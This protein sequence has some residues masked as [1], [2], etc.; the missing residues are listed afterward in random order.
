MQALTDGFGCEERF[1][2]SGPNSLQPRGFSA[3]AALRSA[4]PSVL[5]TPAYYHCRI[6]DFRIDSTGDE[7]VVFS[8]VVP[9]SVC[10]VVCSVDWT[11]APGAAAGGDT[12]T[13]GFP[14]GVGNIASCTTSGTSSSVTFDTFAGKGSVATQSLRTLAN[15]GRNTTGCVQ[16]RLAGLAVPL[17][18]CAPAGATVTLNHVDL[19]FFTPG[20]GGVEEWIELLLVIR[21][22][23]LRPNVEQVEDELTAVERA[24]LVRFGALIRLLADRVPMHLLS[25]IVQYNCPIFAVERFARESFPGADVSRAPLQLE[26][27]RRKQEAPS[28]QPDVADWVSIGEGSDVARI[29]FNDNTGWGDIPLTPSGN[30]VSFAAKVT[31]TADVDV[32]ER[33]ARGWFGDRVDLR[34]A[35]RVPQ[36]ASGF[37]ARVRWEVE[38]DGAFRRPDLPE[39]DDWGER[40][41]NNGVGFG[42]VAGDP[43]I[44]GDGD[45]RDYPRNAWCGCNFAP[46]DVDALR[47]FG[48]HTAAGDLKISAMLSSETDTDYELIVHACDIFFFSG[49]DGFRPMDWLRDAF[50]RCEMQQPPHE[51]VFKLNVPPRS[52]PA[53]AKQVEHDLAEHAQRSYG[54]DAMAPPAAHHT[55]LVDVELSSSATP[56]ALAPVHVP[57]NACGFVAK[58]TWVDQGYGAREGQIGFSQFNATNFFQEKAPHAKGTF[59]AACDM[60]P[61]EGRQ[62]KHLLGIVDDNVPLQ[63]IVGDVSGAT[64]IIDRLDVVVFDAP[65]AGATRF[66]PTEWLAKLRNRALKGR[67]HFLRLQLPPPTFS[68]P[69]ADGGAALFDR[70]MLLM[71][72]PDAPDDQ[73]GL[74][75]TATGSCASTH[76][77]AARATVLDVAWTFDALHFVTTTSDE[78]VHLFQA[79]NSTEPVATYHSSSGVLNPIAVSAN[80]D[81]PVVVGGCGGDVLFW[82]YSSGR[83]VKGRAES[84]VSLLS[85]G[86][87]PTTT[88]FVASASV[89]VSITLWDV[90]SGA[91][92]WHVATSP[93]RGVTFHSMCVLWAEPEVLVGGSDGTLFQYSGSGE[94]VD[95]SDT[96]KGINVLC[97]TQR[98]EWRFYARHTVIYVEDAYGADTQT[99]HLRGGHGKPIVALDASRDMSRL[100][101]SC[102]D[103]KVVVWDL[104]ALGEEA[105]VENQLL[106]IDVAAVAT[107]VLLSPAWCPFAASEVDL[108]T[109]PCCHTSI[110]WSAGA[111]LQP[112]ATAIELGTV[113]VPVGAT[114]FAARIQW[115]TSVAEAAA[116]SDSGSDNEEDAG[117]GGAARTACRLK[118][119]QAVWPSTATVGFSGIGMLNMFDGY[120]PVD[121][122]VDWAAHDM[123]AAA[124]AALSADTQ[125][126]GYAKLPLVVSLPAAESAV[127]HKLDVV[128]FYPDTDAAQELQASHNRFSPQEWLVRALEHH[129][130]P[131][132][133]GWRSRDACT[134]RTMTLRDKYCAKDAADLLGLVVGVP[135]DRDAGTHVPPFAHER[136][137][138]R[139]CRWATS[140]GARLERYIVH[141]N[142]R[143]IK[144]GA[145]HP[146]WLKQC[147]ARYP[148]ASDVDY[149]I[150]TLIP[151]CGDEPPY[152]ETVPHRTELAGFE[153]VEATTLGGLLANVVWS[154]NGRQASAAVA[155]ELFASEQRHESDRKPIVSVPNIF[156]QHAGSFGAQENWSVSPNLTFGGVAVLEALDAWLMDRGTFLARELDG[157]K[158]DVKV[159]GVVANHCDL[160]IERLD[161]ALFRNVG[162]ANADVFSPAE[163]ASAAHEHYGTAA[164][165]SFSQ[166][167]AEWSG[168]RV[169][170]VSAVSAAFMSAPEARDDDSDDPESQHATDED[171][172]G[173]AFGHSSDG[174]DVEQPQTRQG[175]DDDHGAQ[176][177]GDADEVWDQRTRRAVERYVS[178]IADVGSFIRDGVLEQFYVASPDAMETVEEDVCDVRSHGA[179]RGLDAYRHYASGLEH[180]TDVFV[181][182][183]QEEEA[184]RA[185]LT[186]YEDSVFIDAAVKVVRQPKPRAFGPGICDTAPSFQDGH[187]CKAHLLY[188]LPGESLERDDVLSATPQIRCTIHQKRLIPAVGDV[189]GDAKVRKRYTCAQQR[190]ATVFNNI[191]RQYNDADEE[192]D[193]IDFYVCQE[194]DC[195][196]SICKECMMLGTLDSIAARTLQTAY[197]ARRKGVAA[198]IGLIMI[199]AA[200]SMYLPSVKNAFTTVFCHV[201]LACVYPTC[202]SPPEGVFL[203]LVLVGGLVLLFIGVGFIVVLTL[204]TYRR[205]AIILKSNIVDESA[206]EFV[207]KTD[208]HRVPT[209]MLQ[210]VQCDIPRHE[211]SFITARDQSVFKGVYEQYEFRYMTIHASLL[212]FKLAQLGVVL[213]L[214]EPNSLSQLMGAAGVEFAQLVFFSATNPFTNPWIDTLS[215]A[216]CLHQVGQL[217]LM[218][219]FRAD[220]Y[221]DADNRSVAYAMLGLAVVYVVVIVIVVIVIVGIPAYNAITKRRAENARLALERADRKQR[222]RER[223]E[224][225]QGARAAG[226]DAVDAAGNVAA[227]ATDA[228]APPSERGD[229]DAA[230]ETQPS[231]DE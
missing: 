144:P 44:F 19:C 147:L 118:A 95:F 155:L 170:A 218:C 160:T 85:A 222:A 142:V 105:S 220:I 140:P 128:M 226:N 206:L 202:Y 80:A 145:D 201:S 225:G 87:G 41:L 221:E 90:D 184:W 196:F 115:R 84:R 59:W 190:Q 56:V 100:V 64:L 205:K 14:N 139:I 124:A 3:A 62:V 23:D 104:T 71:C 43:N 42:P 178:G 148:T 31:N 189:H 186:K 50:T 164:D 67:G 92:V 6:D 4:V 61:G 13:L 185:R 165:R 29:L 109:P 10:G 69:A 215:K 137:V 228:A 68:V 39:P 119:D 73:T 210:I 18:C 106:T 78:K 197:I 224:Q 72:C 22:N 230:A 86:Q 134:S 180:A 175:D 32:I 91:K 116:D 141:N 37:V 70:T 204:L 176:Q 191:C 103:K 113:D 168:E 146:D 136:C 138:D 24:D 173:P 216:G 81:M 52:F 77:S 169:T 195:G 63:A 57:D 107:R 27:Q 174:S 112:V 193:E 101:S 132:L 181:E 7:V 102:A 114:G 121:T 60:A 163:W 219:F 150:T 51:H 214:G 133:P 54:F 8:P 97:V 213:F 122:M 154:C 199:V 192:C 179:L 209:T 46:G 36:D 129:A 5:P 156:K 1:C 149:Y 34:K 182:R 35:V 48:E 157:M 203:A 82:N 167:L 108:R 172:D 158:L 47:R 94:P 74:W 131:K 117:V 20:W 40:S 55:V 227:D 65:V 111:S 66:A 83:V 9:S 152:D 143:Q 53:T 12:V 135:V 88:R 33:N 161:V 99:H 208:D 211:W 126:G 212:V 16:D 2:F 98:D 151:T 162:V 223:R 26:A 120:A 76:R 188:A 198:L 21:V 110:T 177:D 200:Q 171:E 89:D 93:K 30:H 75:S 25:R 183:M 28:S 217:S 187:R 15:A 127:I 123:T 79:F 38:D 153:D 166:Q 194:D 11:Y 45:Q 96:D 229:N 58:V 231:D 49:A 125:L 207:G 130:P 17:V 159:Y